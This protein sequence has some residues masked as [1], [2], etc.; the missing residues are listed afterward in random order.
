MRSVHRIA[1]QNLLFITI[2]FLWI[3]LIDNNRIYGATIYEIFHINW[4]Y[5][6][7]HAYTFNIWKIISLLSVLTALMYCIVL[8]RE[9]EDNTLLVEQIRKAGNWVVI[10][11]LLLG[12]S[13]VFKVNH[14]LILSYLFSI[15]TFYSLSKL[16]YIFK[17]RD[18]TN[19]AFIHILTRTTMGIY[20]GWFVYLTGFNGIPVILK[21]LKI[22]V[23]SDFNFYASIVILLFTFGFILYKSILCRLPAL[24]LGYTIG[25]LGAYFYNLENGGDKA[26]STIMHY[27]FLIILTI[28]IG[29]IFYLLI[30]KKKDI[31]LTD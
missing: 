25:I 5:L 31:F 10:N 22:E 13:M 27:T 11:Q 12:I 1:F 29:T 6:T 2:N 9:E 4:S 14:Q 30:Q 7:P 19:P 3:I 17:I 16:N 24:L 15:G 21:V 28:A 26:Y 18:N 20:S 8:K 23:L